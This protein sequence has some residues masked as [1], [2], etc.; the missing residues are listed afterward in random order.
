MRL[1]Y[2]FKW[3]KILRI[4]MKIVTQAGF[5]ALIFQICSLAGNQ[6]PIKKLCLIQ[7]PMYVAAQFPRTFT[8]LE[9]RTNQCFVSAQEDLGKI[10]AIPCDQRTYTNTIDA[11]EDLSLVI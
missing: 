7:N 11:C 9:E 5:L 4:M 6:Q 8:E 10:I 3:L 1:V 2:L